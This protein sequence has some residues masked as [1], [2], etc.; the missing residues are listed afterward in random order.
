M[1]FGTYYDK[2]SSTDRF[3]T[4]NC[5]KLGESRTSASWS[6]IVFSI[7]RW[8]FQSH[9]TYW[10]VGGKYEEHEVQHEV[11]GLLEITIAG[12][13]HLSPLLT[14]TIYPTA[15]YISKRC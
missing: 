12:I 3:S 8:G 7:S 10:N 4:A 5:D 6:T 15:K 2:K 1:H 14:Y 11:G 9:W 13:Y